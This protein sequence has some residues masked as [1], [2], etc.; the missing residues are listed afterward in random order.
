MQKGVLLLDNRSLYKPSTLDVQAP[1]DT[2]ID[3]ERVLT[4]AHLRRREKVGT[5]QLQGEFWEHQQN[6][7][8]YPFGIPEAP[9]GPSADLKSTRHH[10]DVYICAKS[11]TIPAQNPT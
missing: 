1:I 6:E 9:L 10:S 7:G 2:S 8:Y 5:S 4:G 3:S 11:L